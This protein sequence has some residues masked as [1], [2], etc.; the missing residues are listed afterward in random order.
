MTTQENNKRIARQ[1][2]EHFDKQNLDGAF[3]LMAEDAQFK[4][5]G[6]P[7]ESPSA[8]AYG[9]DRLRRLFERVL[10][11][12][13]D[14]VRMT[15]KSAIAEGDMVALEM[16]GLGK[17]SNGRAY[18]NEYVI[19]FVIRDGLIR[20]VREYNDTLHAYNVWHAA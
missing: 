11:N 16:E 10:K 13:P 12:V 20:E 9:K 4:I 3:S 17:L 7:A 1:F 19:L 5:P 15:F 6:K 2:F 18:N 8:G 14:G